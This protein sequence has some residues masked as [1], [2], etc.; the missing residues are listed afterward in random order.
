MALTRS[1]RDT[2]AA[3]ARHDVE[4]R[5]ALFEEALQ[6][7]FDGQMDDAKILLRDCINATVGFEV[8]AET[9]GV[10][11]KSL[12]RMVG[13]RGNPTLKNFVGMVQ[14]IQ[15]QTGIKAQARVVDPNACSPCDDSVL[16]HIADGVE[17]ECRTVDA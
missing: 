11:V 13:P 10:P 1:F 12:M 5:V 7:V 9:S 17:G 16:A 15:I 14:A 6:A 4:F 8:L 3:R 2:V